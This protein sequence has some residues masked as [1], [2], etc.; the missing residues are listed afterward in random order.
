VRKQS[1]RV[2][3]TT[4]PQLTEHPVEPRADRV[5]RRAASRGRKAHLG[6]ALAQVGCREAPDGTDAAI[7]AVRGGEVSI[8]SMKIL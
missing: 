8:I 4:S 3:V 1:I 5:A 7:A 2:T 6:G